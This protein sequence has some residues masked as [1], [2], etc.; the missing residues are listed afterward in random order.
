M[1]NYILWY[2]QFNSDGVVSVFTGI[3]DYCSNRVTEQSTT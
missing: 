2:Q 1:E 3:H